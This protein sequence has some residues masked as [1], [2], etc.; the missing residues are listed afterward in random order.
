MITIKNREPRVKVGQNTMFSVCDKAFYLNRRLWPV[1]YPHKVLPNPG[2]RRQM[3]V[4]H[5]HALENFQVDKKIVAN[6]Q[7]QQRVLGPVKKA[8]GCRLVRFCV[9][10]QNE[11]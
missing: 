1:A 11:M 8:R 7:A 9:C 10:S 6:R 4:R 3:S 5:S 2:S